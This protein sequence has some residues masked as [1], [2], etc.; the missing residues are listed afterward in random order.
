MTIK[1][2]PF[3][4]LSRDYLRNRAKMDAAIAGVLERG[5]Y[6]LGPEVEAFESEF[7]R[8]LGFSYAAGVA[9]GTDA[10]S[11]ALEASGAITPNSGDEVI[12]SALSAAFTPLAICRAGAIPRFVDVDPITLQIDCSRIEDVIGA[13][14]RAVVPVHLYGHPCSILSLVELAQRHKL[15]IIEDA[16][17][18]HGSRLSGKSLGSFGHAA[19]FSFYPTKNLGAY[20][21]GG[22]V[23]TQDED[24]IRR[25]RMLRNGGQ[26][27]SYLHELPG[28]CSRL[29]ELQ[30]AVLRTKLRTLEESNRVRRSIAECYDEAFR[31]LDLVLLPDIPDLVPNRHLY[32]VRTPLRDELCRFLKEHG[33]HTLIH[34]PTPLP[35]Q[36]ALK[37]FVHPKQ[38]FPVAQQACREILSLPLYPDLREE[39]IQHIINTV[40]DFFKARK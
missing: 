15:I 28:Y 23:V 36:P 17:Q 26:S 27:S 2:V 8:I 24:L 31:D 4:E 33:I 12:T 25:V 19:A 5:S 3:L 10:L 18:A 30:A 20:G 37:G 34:Y 40:R 11:L 14:T 22:M 38:A 16:C 1:S 35:F 21:D 39:E 32:P 29:D 9:S 7:A 13:K 6:I